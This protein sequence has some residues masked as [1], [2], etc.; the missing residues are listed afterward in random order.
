M[1]K[2]YQ[3]TQ[4]ELVRLLEIKLKTMTEF[5]EACPMGQGMFWESKHYHFY[6]LPTMPHEA[7]NFIL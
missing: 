3:F 1:R 6:S 2:V 5:Y 7:D 4:L